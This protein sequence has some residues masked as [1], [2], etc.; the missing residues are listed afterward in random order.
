M[1]IAV[2]GAGALGSLLAGL[3][4]LSRPGGEIWLVGGEHSTAHLAIIEKEG[5]SIEFSP[6]LAEKW[7]NAAR[8][9]SAAEGY[10]RVKGLRTATGPAQVKGKINLAIVAVKSYQTEKI[11]AQIA[12]CLDPDGLAV[13]VQNGL[14]NLELLQAA[15][16]PGRVT[17]AVTSLGAS[18]L[19]PGRIRFAGLGLTVFPRVEIYGLDAPIGYRQ[20]ELF[21]QLEN[22]GLPLD[23]NDDLQSVIWGKLVVNTAINPLTA[24]L[25]CTN[26]ALL[27]NPASL[28]LLEKV[29]AETA[30]IAR[31]AGIKL[32]YPYQD[33][34]TQARHVARTTAANTS[35]MLA[36]VRRGSPAEIEAINGA[37]VRVAEN[38]GKKAP[39][40]RTLYLLVKALSTRA[41]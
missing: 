20:S 5:L 3:L 39:L 11:A 4:R 15:L 16:G 13:T 22:I 30:G 38:M 23:K 27:E 29:A 37:V 6:E 26:G 34:P 35:S 10:I 36:D 40:N 12:A 33:A 41:V 25:N 19:G 2:F 14:G 32:P 9:K 28:E 18:L 21:A 24:L 8:F 31:R 1:A 17:Q 7:P